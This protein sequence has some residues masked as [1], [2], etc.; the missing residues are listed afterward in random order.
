MGRKGGLDW[1]RARRMYEL[2]GETFLE[3]AQAI[4][5]HR[6]TVS[7]HAKAECWIDPAQI[8]RE[9][10]T[11][12]RERVLREFVER[13][14]EAILANLAE[15]HALNSDL[16]GLARVQI[17][18]LKTGREL[19]VQTGSNKDGDPIYVAEDPIKAI[20]NLALTVKTIGDADAELAA[21]K[22]STWR[23]RELESDG[24]VPADPDDEFMDLCEP[25]RVAKH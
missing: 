4:G 9:G 6:D 1:N 2:E 16:L 24:D 21:L 11:E 10:S 15:K 17:E 5:C 8:Q 14:R 7:A 19:Y 13:D 22:D 12:R 23:D 20:R 25:P 18:R 3:I